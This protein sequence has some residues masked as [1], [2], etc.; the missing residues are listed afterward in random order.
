MS[1]KT[2]FDLSELQQ[3]SKNLQ[4]A[5]DA[6]KRSSKAENETREE[7]IENLSK[8]FARAILRR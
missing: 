8:Y 6:P 1:K 7:T 5:P 3:G 2:A 4:K